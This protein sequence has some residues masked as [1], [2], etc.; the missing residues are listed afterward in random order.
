MSRC[1][2][3]RTEKWQSCGIQ[4]YG[5]HFWAFLSRT[6]L[7][8]SSGLCSC[9]RASSAGLDST[10]AEIISQ[11]ISHF[12]SKKKNPN[13]PKF[14]LLYWEDLLLFFV[15]RDSKMNICGFWIVDCFTGK[16]SKYVKMIN[17]SLQLLF[18]PNFP[19]WALFCWCSLSC[20]LWHNVC[21]HFLCTKILSFVLIVSFFRLH[22]H[23][24]RAAAAITPI[25][26]LV[27]W[28]S[29]QPQHLPLPVSIH[30]GEEWTD[31]HLRWG[32]DEEGSAV[33]CL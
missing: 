8:V 22:L 6:R 2:F 12:S 9:S 19:S 26:D 24:S 31:G 10:R 20:R 7:N 16:L 33:L 13:I 1:W 23:W 14:Q 15:L 28:R 11:I 32:G 27:G 4:F 5:Q 29:A 3:C 17:N 21:E 18:F 30:W 25:P